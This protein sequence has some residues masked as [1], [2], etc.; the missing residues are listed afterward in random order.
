MKNRR[1]FLSDTF[2]VATS[3]T[4]ASALTSLSGRLAHGEVT[5]NDS[6][7]VEVN[8]ETTGLPLLRLPE[9]F[10]YRTYGWT[11]EPMRGGHATPEM[12]DGMAVVGETDGIVTLIRNHEVS[13]IGKPI[14]GKA[15]PYDVQAGGGCV[16]LQFDTNK[17]EWLDS[18]ASLAGTVRN[19]A[20]GVT[21]WGTWLSCE[22]T[23]LGVGERFEK[24]QPFLEQ[25]HGWIFEVSPDPVAPPQPL[26]AMGRMVHEAIAVDRATGIVY[27]TE[28]R[29]HAGFYRFLPNTKGKLADGGK[30]EMLKVKGELDLRGHVENGSQFDVEWVAIEDPERPHSPGSTNDAAGVFEQGK[31][32]GA[33]T[34]AR[35]EGC[36]FGN[37]KVYFDAT[38]GGAMDVGQ[39]WEFDP[40]QQKLTMLFESP[41]AETLNMPDNL[42]VS[43]R[44]GLLLC[45]DS[46]Y[47]KYSQQRIHGL[48][49]RGE[50]SLFA[51]NN[52]QL[53]GEP[54][55]LT[56]D[57]RGREWAGATFSPD[58]K[59]LFVN[60]QTPGITF[61][62]TGPWHETIF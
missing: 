29:G 22:E 7:L 40:E 57:F 25:S 48:N 62:I 17:G 52:V 30:L 33:T 24:S 31:E 49:H 10:R 21:P 54:H 8:D 61:A 4:V 47:G 23:V 1:Q 39:I 19:C 58:G 26:K 28:D 56:G 3:F 42:C 44:G 59:W 43:P 51:I 6:S 20:G 34:F 13:R 60:I 37:G 36:W 9:G 45:E 38:S 32:Q 46:D 27:E 12:H 16:T 41:G 35:L 14:G 15:T 2:S 50:L 5:G 55:G 53:H 11:D 18:W